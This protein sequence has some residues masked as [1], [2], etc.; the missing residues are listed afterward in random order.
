MLTHNRI[1]TILTCGVIVSLLLTACA[2]A[3][4]VVQV[5]K[6]VP[7]ERVV[8]QTVEIE[9]EKVVVVTPTPAPVKEIILDGIFG[10]E[11]PTFDP[12]ISEDTTSVWSVEQIFLGLTD[13]DDD[14]LEVVPELATRW[15]IS[16]DGTVYTF[17]MRDDAVWVRLHPDGTIEELG[18]VTAHDVEY[19][20]KRTLNPLT[21]SPYAYV[22]YEIKGAE[23][24]NTCDPKA[25]SDEEFQALEDGV[26]VKALDDYTVQFTLNHAASYFPSIASLW[27]V[28]PVPQAVIEQYGERWTEPGLIATN[29][30]YMVKEWAH[31]DHAVFVKNPK[32]YGW[33]EFPEAGNVEIINLPIVTEA[34]T[35]MAM[36]EAG[37]IDYLGDPGWGPPLPDMDRIR[38]DPL[39][40]KEFYIAPRLCTYYYGFSQQNPPFKDNVLLRKAFCAAIDRQTLIDTVTKGEQRPAH[41]FAC[42][43]IFGNAADD[44]TIAPYLLDYEEGLK[45]AKEWVAEAGYPEGEG[46]DIVLM[47]NVSEAHAIIAQAIQAMWKEAFPKVKVTIETQEWKVYLKTLAPESPDEDKPNVFRIGWC[48]D[49]LDSN[50]WLNMVFNSKS[51]ENWGRFLNEDFDKLVEEAAKEQ[52]PAKRLELYNQAEKLLVDQ[53][54]GM[55]PIYYYTR[56][57]MDKPYLTRIVSPISMDHVWKWKIDWEAKKAAK[58][59]R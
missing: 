48:A 4:E 18:P 40:S 14:T 42:P 47:H 38:A 19:S 37:E 45:L 25:L 16:E 1:W 36:Y 34:S 3:P 29:G 44:E 43:G 22:I 55:C 23:E 7:V 56:V 12:N 41:T 24:F 33:T 9:K 13:Y 31:Q 54:M 5:E 50:N 35:T 53:E 39:L 59:I 57:T 49:Y 51:H 6:E 17:H 2:A 32:W 30:P 8:V 28:R 26:G 10:T 46:L 52:D 15:D 20:A 58:G 21:A 11:P 27:V